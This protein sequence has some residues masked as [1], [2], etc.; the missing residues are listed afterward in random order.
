MIYC[1]CQ[2]CV[3]VFARTKAKWWL[4]NADI[5]QRQLPRTN[6]GQRGS[7]TVGLQRGCIV[8]KETRR[9][10]ERQRERERERKR[11]REENSEGTDCE[12]PSIRAHVLNFRFVY[13]GFRQPSPIC[14][15][16]HLARRNFAICAPRQ[17]SLLCQRSGRIFH[18]GSPRDLE[19]TFLYVCS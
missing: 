9:T 14:V 18:F 8:G 17:R 16:I 2:S 11:G 6:E 12:R 10:R 15:Q 1:R 7:C 13:T 4:Y 19:L 3:S 5:R